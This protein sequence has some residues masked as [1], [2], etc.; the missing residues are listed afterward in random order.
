MA[1]HKCPACQGNVEIGNELLGVVVSCPLCQHKFSVD[2]NSP[3]Q[4]AGQPSGG[5]RP[6]K[7]C[8]LCGEKVLAVARKCKHC[9]ANIEQSEWAEVSEAPF[10]HANIPQGGPGAAPRYA[11]GPMGQ[12]LPPGYSSNRVAAGICGILVGSFGV[13]K[14]ILGLTTPAVIMLLVTLLTCGFGGIIM[15]V[16]GIAEGIIYLTKSEEEFYERYVVNKQEW[17]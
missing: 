5:E 1:I 14:F 11:S 7:D 12:R 15:H 3:S 10:P 16:I 9:G 13:H 4:P 8:P 2:A 17:F 6:T